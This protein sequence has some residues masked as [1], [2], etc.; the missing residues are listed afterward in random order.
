MQIEEAWQKYNADCEAMRQ[1]FLEDPMCE[2]YPFFKANA[3][4]VL[5]QSQAMAYN[6]VMSAHPDRPLFWKNHFFEPMQFTAHQPNPDFA[7]QLVF[8][9]GARRWRIT[10][11]RNTA[12]CV[13]LQVARG[14]WGDP[15]VGESDNYDLDDFEIGPDG[16]FEIIASADPQPGNWI[17]LNANAP[18]VNIQVRP[19]MYDWETEIPPTFAIEALDAKDDFS[20]ILSEDEIIR[21]LLACGEMLKHCVGRWTTRGSARLV[22]LAGMNNFMWAQGDASR[23]GASPAQR[24]GQMAYEIGHDEALIIECD[25][26][27]ATYWGISLGTWWWETIDP[28]HHMTSINGHQAV[29]GSDGRFRVV[30][31]HRDPGVPNWLDPVTWDAGIVLFRLYRPEGEFSVTTQKIPFAALAEHFPEDIGTVTPDHRRQQIRKR[32]DAVLGWYGY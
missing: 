28:T 3:H 2:K 17:Q 11:K 13:D 1:R 7:Y 6:L 31:S 9:N 4:F 12:H 25:A 24:Y 5:L 19:A 26:P 29:I 27:K 30:L 10:G 20:P 16:S 8:L 14:W 32:G 21:R 15:D 23:G 18:L 22:K